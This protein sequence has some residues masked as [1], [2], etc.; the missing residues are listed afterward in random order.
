M[1][2]PS[3]T[4]R[5]FSK[6]GGAG[7]GT[8]YR[9]DRVARPHRGPR[10]AVAATF[11]YAGVRGTEGRRACEPFRAD[12]LPAPRGRGRYE[13]RAPRARAARVR[14]SSRTSAGRRSRAF[15]RRPRRSARSPRPRCPA[16]RPPR[17]DLP[18][19][20]RGHARVAL[21]PRGT[22]GE[23][24]RP[25]PERAARARPALRRRRA[26]RAARRTAH[27]RP[28]DRLPPRGRRHPTGAPAAIRGF[29]RCPMAR[30]AGHRRT[31]LHLFSHD[32]RPRQLS[33]HEPCAYERAL[34]GLFRDAGS[35]PWPRAAGLLAV[36]RHTPPR[37]LCPLLAI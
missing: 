28:R 23:A 21:P 25:S 27:A 19:P 10:S 15:D 29:R 32:Q 24:P 13:W 22:A 26:D 31:A 11:P 35:T 16:A 6:P 20:P 9:S 37:L 5:N 7:I 4:R 36:V 14:R 3:P 2:L 30:A 1:R 34:L 12:A 33:P 8:A 17:S 18:P